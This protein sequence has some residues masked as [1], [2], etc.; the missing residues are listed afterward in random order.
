MWLQCRPCSTVNC[1]RRTPVLRLMSPNKPRPHAARSSI[2]LASRAQQLCRLSPSRLTKSLTPPQI[3]RRISP[4]LSRLT[5]R[6]T[7][8]TPLWPAPLHSAFWPEENDLLPPLIAP[9]SRILP[10]ASPICARIGQAVAD[11]PDPTAAKV[12]IT[13]CPRG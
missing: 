10:A 13:P 3:R 11:R 4:A 1:K 2:L 12:G 9:A 5:H 7:R 6:T 8:L